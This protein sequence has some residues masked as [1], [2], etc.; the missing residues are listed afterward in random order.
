MHTAQHVHD[1]STPHN[2]FTTR[3]PNNVISLEGK[4]NVP[5]HLPAPS[6]SLVCLVLSPP[7]PNPTGANIKAHHH[8]LIVEEDSTMHDY[9]KHH[10]ASECNEHTIRKEVYSLSVGHLGRRRPLGLLIRSARHGERVLVFFGSLWTLCRAFRH[11]LCLVF[12]STHQRLRTQ[13]LQSAER[14]ASTPLPEIDRD[15]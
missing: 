3:R 12:A 11:L 6:P 14:D 5:I 7:N 8:H 9:Q 10:H 4:Q 15:P 2:T 13:R 1:T